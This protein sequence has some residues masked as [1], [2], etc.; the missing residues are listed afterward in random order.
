MKG[1]GTPG[2]GTSGGSSGGAGQPLE[3]KEKGKG[4]LAVE[5]TDF[6][7][8]KSLWQEKLDCLLAKKEQEK[9]LIEL[10]QLQQLQRENERQTLQ[11]LRSEGYCVGPRGR[12]EAY[13]LLLAKQIEQQQ[14]TQLE[15]ER[16]DAAYAAAVAFCSDMERDSSK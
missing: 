1:L 11:L 2:A 12:A 10:Q 5:H 4:E 13:D 14:Q 7:R 9:I 6:R 3:G 8:A 16:S 15:Q